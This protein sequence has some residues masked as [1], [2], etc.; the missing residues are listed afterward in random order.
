MPGSID[1]PLAQTLGAT[2]PTTMRFHQLDGLGNVIGTFQSG[3]LSQSVTYDSWG[4]P[5]LQGNGDNRLL[6]KGLMWEG[7]IVSLY[8][9]RNRW[10]D[11]E[12]GRFLSEDPLGLAS[13]A[14]VY[15][16]GGNDPVNRQDPSGL[17]DVHLL[18]WLDFTTRSPG[19]GTYTYSGCAQT[20]PNRI[21]TG[22]RE[23]PHCPTLFGCGNQ[24]DELSMRERGA[25][26]ALQSAG[27]F[28]PVALLTGGIGLKM[29]RVSS[30]AEAGWT[31]TFKNAHA[32]RHLTERVLDICKP[33]S[34]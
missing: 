31:V 26:E 7:D 13:V 1:Q 24:P 4:V 6:W 9:M 34:K 14:N 10:Y 12:L 28:D 2:S 20:L 16:F 32:A 5:T 30:V 18:T 17:C 15:A 8:Y 22:S 25:R 33:R 21:I 3:A 19:V 29:S 27:F 23:Q 11:P